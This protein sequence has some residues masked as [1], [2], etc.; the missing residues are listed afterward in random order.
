MTEPTPRA[1]VARFVAAVR[2]ELGDLDPD[3]VDELTGGLAADLTAAFA[4]GDPASPSLGDP[5]GYARDLR[6]AAG[7]EPRV[8]PHRRR[9]GGGL[10]K[11][12]AAR[13]SQ[14]RLR[15]EAQAWWPSVRDFLVT[16]RP[17]WWVARAYAVYFVL[18]A[19]SGSYSGLLPFDPASLLL[20]V[21]LV[22]LS[23]QVGRRGAS[24]ALSI[25]RLRYAVLGA[26]LLAIAA[27]PVL[28]E[29]LEDQAFSG[30]EYAA[31]YEEGYAYP[32]PLT[33]NGREVINICPT[34]PQAIR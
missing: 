5:V 15:L 30:G 2:A 22:V 3:V 19:L 10:R 23:V 20:L 14:A 11:R 31:V 33:V 26:N 32:M 21:A 6:V 13:M 4:A 8:Y 17:A 27:L 34:T 9:P 1:D 28:G 29:R 16:L 12:G 25:G 7:L 24:R 18:L